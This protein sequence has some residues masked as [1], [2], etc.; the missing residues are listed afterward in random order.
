[1]DGLLEG[2]PVVGMVRERLK[3]IEREYAELDTVWYMAG[4]PLHLCVTSPCVQLA[5]LTKGKP[6]CV[7]ACCCG[8]SQGA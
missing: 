2:S 3:G 5:T 6:L 1:M 7:P 4:E 8:T